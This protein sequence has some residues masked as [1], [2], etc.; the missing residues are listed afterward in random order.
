MIKSTEIIDNI[1]EYD[2]PLQR[3]TSFKTGGVAEIF[4][5]PRNISELRKVLQFCEKEQK[6]FFIFG[7]GSN[8]LVND[9]GV[10]GVVI[11][12]GGVEFIK[13]IRD[14]KNIF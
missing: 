8:V 5:E 4:A 1:F 7:N 14:G 11:H 10:Q 13:V 6:K 12:L 9:N 2:V 3:Y